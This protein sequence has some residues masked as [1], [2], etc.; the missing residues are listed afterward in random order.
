MAKSKSLSSA[1]VQDVREWWHSH[2]MD[3]QGYSGKTPQ[4]D[5]E[6]RQFFRTADAGW[7]KNTMG[8]NSPQTAYPGDLLIDKQ[9]IAGKRV[10]EIGC[11]MGFW[12]A[13]FAGWGC[14]STGID[15]TPMA[16]S[17]TRKRLELSG[18]KA[19]VLQMDA[20][21]LAFPDESFD[22]V[23]SW[24]VIHHSPHTEKIVKEIQRVL[25][26]GGEFGIMIYYKY[27][28]HSLYVLFRLGILRGEVFKYG[29][30]GIQNIH[31][32]AEDYG[33]P[34]LARLWSKRG[35]RRLLKPLRVEKISCHSER[36]VAFMLFPSR[37]GINAF[38]S[39]IAPDGVKDFIT[40]HFGH[41]M[42]AYGKKPPA[43]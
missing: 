6:F 29:L 15:L 16:V 26:P 12:T 1:T 4:T 43:E 28:I 39:R 2:P 25:K 20:G 10:L 14:Q 31:S 23:W 17:M 21:T 8:F 33:G 13:T 7:W 22:F 27:S 42:F 32:E 40:R 11:G 38:L 41:A 34:P 3:Y 24:G 36:S 37:L 9:R 35:F 19:E 18:L 30:Q 5:E